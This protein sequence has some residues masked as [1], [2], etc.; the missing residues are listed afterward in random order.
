MDDATQSES[1]SGTF[2][3]VNK[4]GDLYDDFSSLVIDQTKW[5]TYEFVREI[6]EGKLRSKVRSSTASAYSIFGSSEFQN[7]YG[8]NVL[9]TK[10]TPTIY[11]NEQGANASARIGGV[12]YNDGTPGG[13]SLGL[14]GAEVFIGGT[15][16]TPIGGWTVW[17]YSDWTGNNAAVV[18]SGTFTTPITVGNTYTLFLWWDGSQFT[19]KI[20]NESANYTP[21]TSILPPYYRWKEIGTR[22]FTPVGMEATIDALFDDAMVNSR[23]S[24]VDFDGDGKTD[25]SIWRPGNGVW[26]AI[27]SKD[28]SML[29]QQWGALGDVPAAADY[30]AD[31]KADI[32]VYRASAGAWYVMPSGGGAPYN[33]GWGG[34]ASD[35][36][37]PGDYDGDR[38]ADIAV[39]RASA[40]AWYITPSGGGAPYGLGWGG[41]ASDKP[42][43]GDYD[44]D[45]KTDIAVYRSNSGGW[46]IMPSLGAPAYGVAWGGDASDIPVPGDYDGD[47]NADIAVYRASAGVWYITLSGGGAAYGL[48]WGGDASDIPVPG[49]YDGDG[50]TDIAIYRTNIG[51]WYIIPSSGAAPY[52]ASWGGDATDLPLTTNPASYM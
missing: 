40:G 36:P 17:T 19:F 16:V 7:P 47:G 1:I 49:D 2:D 18:A 38:K 11:E 50:R 5:N 27:S 45:G 9:Q 8:M 13:G 22:I 35:I 21:A 37:I 43:P 33:L 3:N 34:D 32:A 14:V 31:R 6:S 24:I 30:D 51:G 44:G 28:R 20:G 15:G 52:G 41:D 46:Y 39:Y 25:I 29:S 48:S 23:P 4:N 26:Y 12:F 42:V 10:V